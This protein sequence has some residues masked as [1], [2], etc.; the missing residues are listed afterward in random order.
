MNFKE[1]QLFIQFPC[2]WFSDSNFVEFTRSHFFISKSHFVAHFA[3]PWTVPPKT[4]TPLPPAT[5]TTI[6]VIAEQ[7]VVK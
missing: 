2:I 6:Y 4:A 3:T 1:S 7:K 5:T